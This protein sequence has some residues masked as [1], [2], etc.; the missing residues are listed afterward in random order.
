MRHDQ[1]YLV[2]GNPSLMEEVKEDQDF[3]PLAEPLA[4]L[5]LGGWVEDAPAT[6]DDGNLLRAKLFALMYLMQEYGALD[7]IKAF[8]R[9][10][11]LSGPFFDRWWEIN[12]IQDNITVPDYGSKYHAPAGLARGSVPHTG[13]VIVDDWLNRVVQFEPSE[14]GR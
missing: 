9:S 3:W 8:F 7:K 4:A 5:Q 2:R 11:T 6:S 1:Y 14:S 12:R 10:G 13:S